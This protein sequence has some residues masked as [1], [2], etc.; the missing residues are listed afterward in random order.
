MYTVFRVTHVETLISFSSRPRVKGNALPSQ[1]FRVLWTII[2]FILQPSYFRVLEYPLISDHAHSFLWI[3]YMRPKK[4][5]QKTNIRKAITLLTN[6]QLIF[7]LQRT[8]RIRRGHEEIAPTKSK[9]TTP[10]PPKIRNTAFCKFLN[11][12][13]NKTLQQSYRRISS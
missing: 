1:I 13:I 4:I 9:T 10:L 3:E 6:T 2:L 5:F 12:Y 7:A 8:W 11:T